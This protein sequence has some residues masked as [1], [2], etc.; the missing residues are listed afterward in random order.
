MVGPT[1]GVIGIGA[2]YAQLAVF[3]GIVHDIVLY[4]VVAA[5][6]RQQD[7]ISMAGGNGVSRDFVIGAV[8]GEVDRSPAGKIRYGIVLDNIV[9]G[10]SLYFRFPCDEETLAP[11]GCEADDADMASIPQVDAYGIGQD[12]FLALIGAV[13]DFF[14]AFPADSRPDLVGICPGEN[15]HGIAGS[16]AGV[17]LGDGFPGGGHG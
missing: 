16:E 8:V 2:T 9:M 12:Y 13:G 14:V 6:Y 1:F 5:V 17:G 11:P 7:R 15:G 4:L 3:G 10:I